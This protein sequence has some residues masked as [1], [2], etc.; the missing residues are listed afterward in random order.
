MHD[1]GYMF[2]GYWGLGAVIHVI[3]WVLILAA[4]VGVTLLL[5]RSFG[6][7]GRGDEER[8]GPSSALDQLNERYARGEIDREEYLQRKKDILER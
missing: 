6:G 1:G 5:A 2:G 7:G 3:V 4:I 8:G